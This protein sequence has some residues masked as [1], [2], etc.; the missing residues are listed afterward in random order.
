MRPAGIGEWQ[1]GS[2]EV[3]FHPIVPPTAADRTQN[4]MSCVEMGFR[5]FRR[6]SKKPMQKP[7]SVARFRRRS[8]AAAKQPEAAAALV[9]DPI[10][11]AD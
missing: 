2:L 8:I 10:V 1:F 9:L 5:N 6:T 4:G 7:A 11:V 3:D